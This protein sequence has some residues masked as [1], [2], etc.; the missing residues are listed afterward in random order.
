[1]HKSIFVEPNVMVVPY[2]LCRKLEDND[3]IINRIK[4]V[5]PGFFTEDLLASLWGMRV[6]VPE[7]G[8]VGDLNPAADVRTG[9]DFKYQW[10]T[11]KDPW[12]PYLRTGSDWKGGTLPAPVKPA[13]VDTEDIVLFAHMAP[14]ASTKQVAFIYE[15]AWSG[16]DGAG[17]ST[18]RYRI[19]PNFSDAIIT[20]RFYDFQFATIDETAYFNL[21]PDSHG[22]GTPIPGNAKFQRAWLGSC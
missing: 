15:F 6:V 4:Y 5:M 9:V 2:Q 1:M 21:E 10:R 19:D 12:T 17:Q 8:I 22:Y 20:R 18:Y 16:P 14:M 13:P 3:Q 11:R 7:T